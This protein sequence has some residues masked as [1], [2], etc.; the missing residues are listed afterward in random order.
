MWGGTQLSW[1]AKWYLG[2]HRNTSVPWGVPGEA[3]SSVSK[4]QSPFRPEEVSP[5]P[6][7]VSPTPCSS[8][9][10][11]AGP[12][13]T[14]WPLRLALRWQGAALVTISWPRSS[15]LM[16]GGPITACLK[17][18][19]SPGFPVCCHETGL[20]IVFVLPPALP[21]GLH[22]WKVPLGKPCPRSTACER[23]GPAVRSLL[24]GSSCVTPGVMKG[25]RFLGVTEIPLV[26]DK[27]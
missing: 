26:R 5:H 24:L 3:R 14:P 10:A 27:G 2:C 19:P 15:L 20:G 21:E 17:A 8:L 9:P 18:S 6:A 12:C 22:K 13:G 7:R 16:S 4:M 25:S 1:D 23:F 11:Q